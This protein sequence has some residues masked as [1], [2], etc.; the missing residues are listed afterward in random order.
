MHSDDRRFMVQLWQLD[1]NRQQGRPKSQVTYSVGV[2]L[3]DVAHVVRLTDA[4]L[5][6]SQVRISVY[7]CTLPVATGPHRLR[8]WPWMRFSELLDVLV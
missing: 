5:N 8:T 3:L 2:P 7:A 4:T 6:R 1:S